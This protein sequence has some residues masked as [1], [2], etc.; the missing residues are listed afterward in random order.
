MLVVCFANPLLPFL[1]GLDAEPRSPVSHDQPSG[2]AGSNANP[3]GSTDAPDR[4]P[5]PHAQVSC[6]R[7]THTHCIVM[8][9]ID[10][11]LAYPSFVSAQFDDKWNRWNTRHARSRGHTPREPRLPTQQ[12]WNKRRPAAADATDASDVCW[13][14]RRWRRKWNGTHWHTHAKWS[15]RPSLYLTFKL[16]NF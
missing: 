14:R 16:I 12:R 7:Q 5:R 3:T 9:N 4:S 6:H 13:R 11:A 1:L 15:Y 10:V 8:E 2:H